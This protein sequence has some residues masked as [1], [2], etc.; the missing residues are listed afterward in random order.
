MVRT[1]PKGSSRSETYLPIED[2]QMGKVSLGGTETLKGWGFDGSDW[3]LGDCV[4]VDLKSSSIWGN[5]G[6]EQG[7]WLVLTGFPRIR[8]VSWI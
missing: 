2:N 8:A 5:V 3:L 6:Y 7:T 1:E 4:P